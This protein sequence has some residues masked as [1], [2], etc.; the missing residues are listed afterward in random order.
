MRKLLRENLFKKRQPQK[1]VKGPKPPKVYEY[2][3]FRISIYDTN[4]AKPSSPKASFSSKPSTPKASFSSKPSTPR[5]S[6]SSKQQTSIIKKDVDKP[7]ITTG[8]TERSSAGSNSLAEKPIVVTMTEED[9]ESI[10]ESIPREIS[11]TGSPQRAVPSP[12][13]H[14][15]YPHMLSKT[16]SFLKK[17][18][19]KKEQ[20]PTT[21]EQDEIPS[22]LTEVST[23]SYSLTVVDSE[24]SDDLSETSSESSSMASEL[25]GRDDLNNINQSSITKSKISSRKSPKK[26]PR[27]NRGGAREWQEGCTSTAHMLTEGASAVLTLIAMTER[28]LRDDVDVGCAGSIGPGGPFGVFTQRCLTDTTA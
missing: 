14:V 10:A 5:A 24:S 2:E 1:E 20:S 16:R 27:G 6:L 23:F 22:S 3:S 17:K 25:E 19:K 12:M 21:A 26:Q 15:V 4:P 8:T 11:F 18:K 7:S 28:D 13:D 9:D